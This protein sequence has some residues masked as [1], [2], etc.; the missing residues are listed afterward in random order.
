MKQYSRAIP[1]SFLAIILTALSISLGAATARLDKKPSFINADDIFHHLKYLA[2]DELKGRL[3]GSKEAERAASYIA[4][5]FRR[6]RLK[7]VADGNS[8]FQPFSFIAAVKLGNNN[9]LKIK[10][11]NQEKEYRVKQD[12]MPLGF[13]S[14]T[15][16]SGNAVFAGYGISSSQNNIDDYAGIN[17]KGRVVMVL[18]G[19]FDGDNPHSTFSF[20]GQSRY[21]AM[22]AREHG[23]AAIL[24]IAEEEDFKTDELARLEY[25][26]S[27]GDSGI[28]AAAISRQAAEQILK[29]AGKDLNQIHMQLA[30]SKQ[31]NSFE[32]SGVNVSAR[33]E[34]IKESRSANNVLGYLEGSDSQLKD[35][36]VVIGAHYD[37]L[38]LGGPHSLAPKKFGEIHNGADDN[39]SGTAGLLALARA[40]SDRR[41][42]I[43]RSLLFIA[44]SAEEEGLLGSRHY[45]KNPVLPLDKTAAMIN[46]DMIGRQKNNVL[47]VGGTGSSP[48][49]KQLLEKINQGPQFQLKFEDGSFG[50]SSD[51]ASFYEANV[52]ILFFFTGV[53][54]DY[55]RP[56]DDYDKI[57]IQGQTRIVEFVYEVARQ[58][59]S[60]Q[61][62]PAFT[63]IKGGEQQR[64]SGFR[65]YLGTVPDYAEQTEGVK[66]SGVREGSPAEKA[67]I[68][69]GDIIVK[70]GN[71]DIKNIYDY[72]YALQEMKGG[73]E[74]E[75]VV[76]RDGQKL[77]LKIT[78]EKR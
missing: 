14:S 35:E 29:A 15:Q 61:E 71:R 65:V 74:I 73:E 13:S 25:D 78:P 8:Y 66:L 47:I 6:Y 45:V 33:I 50:G 4:N 20:Y 28:A 17:A 36:L 12:F 9:S 41:D 2:S 77:S 44:F 24:F 26:N 67:G 69:G 54:E 7:A 52:P 22:V 1:I 55:H 21:K 63:K 49:W 57:N 11:G 16:V 51:H 37:H 59:A 10:S 56:S 34:V 76:M 58:V 30:H 3:A 64:G 42:E 53:H 72:T 68:R 70:L 23:A 18:P 31:S 39:A 5:E 43:K 75:I 48:G 27:F 62:R 60:Q 40:F 38:G 46:M 32:L 19:T